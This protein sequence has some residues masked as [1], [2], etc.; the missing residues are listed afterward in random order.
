MCVVLILVDSFLI[1]SQWDKLTVFFSFSKMLQFCFI[2]LSRLGVLVLGR[3]KLN[4]NKLICGMIIHFAFAF[5][6]PSLRATF[7]VII[8]QLMP[9]PNLP[10]RFVAYN[11][12]SK[13]VSMFL[14]AYVLHWGYTT[15]CCDVAGADYKN[16]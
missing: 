2:S 1:Y 16:Q 5:R 6:L 7:F 11:N 12:F 9:S 4:R 13:S 3:S 8:L 10:I 14:F 15:L